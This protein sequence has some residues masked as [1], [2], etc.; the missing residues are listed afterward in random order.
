MKESKEE[1]RGSKES[2]RVNILKSRKKS[3]KN[4][5]VCGE[6]I[7]ASGNQESL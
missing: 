5:N 2:R 1:P 7:V 4:G 3:V 6:V